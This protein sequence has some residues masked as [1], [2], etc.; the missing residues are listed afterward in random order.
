M[1]RRVSIRLAAFAA[2]GTV[3]LALAGVAGGAPVKGGTHVQSTLTD[4]APYIT[5]RFLDSTGFLPTAGCGFAPQT[6]GGAQLTADVHGW[7]GPPVDPL[8]TQDVDLHAN[9]HGTVTDTAGNVYRLNGSFA[10]SGMSAWSLG[11]VP[12]D[13]AG[14]LTLTAHGRTVSG[15]ALFRVVADFPLEWDFTFTQIEVCRV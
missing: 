2:A 5:T 9:V 11:E 3:V 10:Q 12:F 6:N 15:A 1:R 13:G 14:H 7:A 8:G 4:D